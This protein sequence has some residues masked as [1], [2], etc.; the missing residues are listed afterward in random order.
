MSSITASQISTSLVS[1]SNEAFS[2]TLALIEDLSLFNLAWGS[3]A[4]L[5]QKIDN[6]VNRGTWSINSNNFA[7]K[8][9]AKSEK[10][11]DLSSGELLLR[12]IGGLQRLVDAA[13]RDLRTSFDLEEVVED[14]CMAAVKI[15]REDTKDKKV[16]SEKFTGLDVG[17]MIEFQIARIFTGLKIN[18]EDLSPQQRECLV[19]RTRDFLRSLPADQQ[20]FIMDKLGATDMSD[21]AIRNA[22][23]TGAIWTAFAAAVN[24]FGFAFYMAASHLLAVLS[25][26][27]L[28]F[29]AYVGLSSFIAV[30]ASPWMVPVFVTFGT[31]FYIHKNS[32]M[33]R[34]MAPLLVTSLCLSGI[35][36]QGSDTA[37]QGATVEDA[38]ASWGTAR[39]IRDEKRSIS[40]RAKAV[41]D[42][43]QVKL[44]ATGGQI[45]S[46]RARKQG[47]SRERK[48]LNEKLTGWVIHSK[49]DIAKGQWGSALIASAAGVEE[50]EAQICTA[51]HKRDQTSG[52]WDSIVGHAEYFLSTVSLNAQ[53]T[54]AKE[55]LVQKV[56]NTWQKAG[57]AFPENAA[58]ILQK[59]EEKTS[60]LLANEVEINRL[61]VQ[62]RE[63][64]AYLDRAKTEAR[65]AAV[66]L[67]EA[68]SRYYGL[69]RV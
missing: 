23:A 35:E 55:A 40:E 44:T 60:E 21:A 46:A 2:N 65:K 25:I 3:G 17:S 9:A 45:K 38:L 16:N 8:V 56:R 53:L 54:S 13:P 48:A 39:N 7:E 24:V 31:W 29:G 15:L 49:G 61:T 18:M 34:S 32:A 63:E 30:L 51:Q 52:F 27:L 1:A 66:A 62:E 19:Q 26:G 69:G 22:I 10:F 59:I 50:I 43:A 11:S 64:S 41:R 5:V 28:P 12:T 20:R 37:Q 4:D 68:E 47:A 57:N 67:D 6:K 58:A 14:I 42:Q 33:R 36:I